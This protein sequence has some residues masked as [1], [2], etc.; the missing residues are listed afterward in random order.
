ML[1]R[2]AAGLARGAFLRA[3][4]AIQSELQRLVNSLLV[5]LGAEVFGFCG[6]AMLLHLAALQRLSG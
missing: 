5:A 6:E 3:G 2:A 4:S 1:R